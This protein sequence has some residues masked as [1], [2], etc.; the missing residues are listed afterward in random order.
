MESTRI[1]LDRLNPMQISLIRL[2][3]RGLTEAQTLELRRVL[4]RHYSAMLKQEVERTI[5]EKGYT[6][7]DFDEMLN[8]PS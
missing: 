4:V 8:S 3:D 7:A 6:Q 5:K 1:S 2:F